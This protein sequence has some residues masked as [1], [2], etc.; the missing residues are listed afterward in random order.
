MTKVTSLPAAGQL[1]LLEEFL[2]LLKPQEPTEGVFLHQGIDP[3]LSQL[4]GGGRKIHQVPQSHIFGAVV[5][6]HL[7]A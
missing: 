1:S 2:V 5:D 7:K 6:V 3:A 4:E